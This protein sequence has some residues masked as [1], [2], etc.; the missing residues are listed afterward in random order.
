MLEPISVTTKPVGIYG[1][2]D[3][4][5]I[6]GGSPLTQ[7][8]DG[9]RKTNVASGDIASHL[10]FEHDEGINTQAVQPNE[11][12]YRSDGT[13]NIISVYALTPGDRFL[14]SAGLRNRGTIDMTDGYGAAND[15]A[16]DDYD[17]YPFN[18]PADGI[19]WSKGD[20][21]FIDSDGKWTNEAT[22]DSIAEEYAYFVVMNTDTANTYLEIS[23]TNQGEI[24]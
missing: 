10:A 18:R 21:G 22:A 9:F 4:E 11:S 5:D 14:L 24:S 7:T 23:I 1:L 15:S 17:G 16:A 13:S 20:N 19:T 3:S 8:S 6:V 12:D 2:K